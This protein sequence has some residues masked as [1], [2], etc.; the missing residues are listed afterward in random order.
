[1]SSRCFHVF[2]AV[3]LLCGASFAAEPAL[4]PKKF[5]AVI[6]GFFG[7]TYVIELRD[8]TLHYT[9][10]KRST[11]PGPKPT[12]SGASPNCVWPNSAASARNSSPFTSKNPSGAGITET[13]I[14]TSSYFK[15]SA[16]IRSKAA[17]T[18][19]YSDHALETEG[20]NDYRNTLTVT[21]PPSKNY[22]VARPSNDN[23]RNAHAQL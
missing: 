6:G 10:H 9:E 21:S 11:G 14:F 15:S 13:I 16:Q 12:A 1:M 3:G 2:L 8:G 18:L 22:S 5:S 20:S 7:P 17:K 4:T 19:Q 23:D